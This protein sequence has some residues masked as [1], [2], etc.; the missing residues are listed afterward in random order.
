M[1]AEPLTAIAAGITTDTGAVDAENP[2]PG[3]AAFREADQEFFHGRDAEAEEL[4]RLV[5][6]DRLAVLYGLSGLGKTSLLQAG[7][8]P[9]LRRENVLPVRI[10]LD[11]SENHLRLI[12]QVKAAI[13]KEAADKG[14]ETPTPQPGETLWELFHRQGADFWNSRNRLV[15]P[16]LAFDQF[17]EIFTLGCEDA[18]T[19]GFLDEIASLAE[20]SPPESVRKR[21]DD[22][23][24]EARTFS[25]S[26]HPY[27]LLLSFREDFL[28]DLEE[29]RGRMRS[30]GSNR[31][32]LQRMNGANA[33][34]VV[35]RAGGSLIAPDAAERVV[36]FVAGRP[37]D[38][39]T[40][41]ESFE[42]EPALLSVVCR[43]LNNKRRAEDEP[44]ITADLL[45]GSREEILSD[46]YKRSVEDLDG[47]VRTFIEESLLTV[48]GFRDSVALEN[49]L[50][51][52]GVTQEAI[53]KLTDRRLLRIEDRGGVERLELTHDVLTRVIRASRDSRREREALEQAEAAR[54]EAEERERKTRKN[55]E[56]QNR[57]LVLV[58]VLLAI[59]V[60]LGIW[61]FV[62]QRA[63]Q[64][65]R[66]ISD[67]GVSA[68]LRD[69]QSNKALAYLARALRTDPENF[70]A[71]TWLTDLLLR[72]TWPVPVLGVRD[73]E[74]FVSAEM[75]PDGQ[76]LL[77]ATRTGRV[78]IWDAKTGR[79][80]GSPLSGLK[81]LSMAR[82]SPD[83]VRIVTVELS[84]ASIW[85]AKTGKFVAGFPTNGSISSI[86][87]SS[88]GLTIATSE[89]DKITLWDL[90]TRKRA[91]V[92]FLGERY[93]FYT[94]SRFSPTN[95]QFLTIETQPGK[96]SVR[97]TIW[98]LTTGRV[99]KTLS[100]PSSLYI[101]DAHFNQDGSLLAIASREG[102]GQVW[103][104][105]SG[106]PV[107]E[108]FDHGAPINSIH[109]SP[110]ENKV[111]TASED[112]TA[113]VWDAL[114]GLPLTEP[115]QHA[116]AVLDARF[117]SDGRQVVTASSDGTARLWEIQT[118]QS[119]SELLQ[120]G[121]Q[122]ALSLDAT[123]VASFL[124]TRVS[125]QEL[126]SG[127]TIGSSIELNHPISEVQF[128]PDGSRL[129][130]LENYPMKGSSKYRSPKQVRIWE[131][132]TARGV[133]K[134][135][136]AEGYLEFSKDMQK[137]AISVPGNKI[138]ILDLKKD[139]VLFKN[140]PFYYFGFSP[141][142]KYMVTPTQG[143][144]TLK[145]WNV[146]ATAQVGE[147]LQHK[148]IITS[149]AFSSDGHLLITTTKDGTARI[150]NTRS[151]TPRSE[152]LPVGDVG[153]VQFSP[154]S[155]FFLV[156]RLG[157]V[158]AFEVNGTVLGSRLLIDRAYYN[159]ISTDGNVVATSLGNS[160]YL[161]QPRTGEFLA[162]PFGESRHLG[163]PRLRPDGRIFYAVVPDLLGSSVH[164][165]ELAAGTGEDVETLARLAEAAGGFRLDTDG[166][167]VPLENWRARI[168]EMRNLPDDSDDP[169]S[170]AA[171]ARWFF[172][173]RSTRTISPLSKIT[174]PDY[175]RHRLARGT[176][177][178]RDEVLKAYPDH[179]LVLEELS[180]SPS[181]P[182][183]TPQ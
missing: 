60:I 139:R 42:V 101:T 177:E 77:T 36:R 173:D 106:Q 20:G 44:Q 31:L 18:E 96:D 179:P 85:E 86:D 28:P 6:R 50:N 39:Q 159:G 99:K 61:G 24:A 138:N 129:A 66:S 117:S 115:L 30:I 153:N 47:R 91:N 145:I 13:V 25:F 132:E 68:S 16:L 98:D 136:F 79:L 51:C 142:G 53:D 2:W 71:R 144:A 89:F 127:Y 74:G 59:V 5:L 166:R 92:L 156:S 146:E 169:L 78:Q 157:R 94:V 133:G 131:V 3:L 155:S 170:A 148:N 100:L 123:M 4:F 176:K 95:T 120:V 163:S 93:S 82:F 54:E 9:R 141:D 21:L 35:T 114:T 40:P 26:R 154:D 81:G 167:L 65:V 162:N 116:D 110:K 122:A 174:V 38:D 125:I 160:F 164:A 87:F 126:P 80:I 75:S 11:F 49:A 17:E 45:K 1:S 128:S 57:I 118:G 12:D 151:G 109:F 172:A 175:I 147:D 105:D 181:S 134:P 52:P 111:V 113:R 180:R 182:P 171:L 90:R 55:F 70:A 43:E 32:R 150:W 73:E 107:G 149:L 102:I 22:E 67:L 27:K 135:F 19:D 121:D 161:W 103:N 76:S 83:G 137:V 143:P 14:V 62:Q 7:L 140:L 165:W 112:R 130:T 46:F 152:F 104:V 34:R 183:Q 37:E 10:R 168:D 97:S 41:L 178:A 158:S 63:G 64:K 72:R 69:T 108:P 88:D 29:L 23:P 58:S 84:T 48:S 8:F 119:G 15:T 56:R 124:G 33:L